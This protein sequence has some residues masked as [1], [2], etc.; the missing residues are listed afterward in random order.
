LRGPLR[1]RGREEGK[2][3]R[4]GDRKEKGSR[5]RDGKGEDRGRVLLLTFRRCNCK[6]TESYNQLDDYIK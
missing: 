1:G 2:G 5:R 4:K 3:K 6:A